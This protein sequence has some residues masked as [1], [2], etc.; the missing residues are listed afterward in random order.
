MA[1]L[2]RKLI[3]LITVKSVTTEHAAC[4]STVIIIATLCTVHSSQ[5]ADQGRLCFID[6]ANKMSV[7]EEGVCQNGTKL[8]MAD[9]G[10]TER[11]A[12]KGF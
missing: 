2:D 4:Y 3:V 7:C 6:H 5:S 10:N 1:T 8:E 12:L 9:Y 11:R